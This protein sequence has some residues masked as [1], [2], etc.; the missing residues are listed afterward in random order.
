MFK[1]AIPDSVRLPV[2]TFRLGDRP[3]ALLIEDVVEV[4]AMVEAT[5]IPDAGPELIGMVNRRGMILPL[6]DLRVLFQQPASVVNSQSVFIVAQGGDRQIGLV[7]DEIRQVDYVDALQMSDA[8][9]TSRY[10]HGLI[11][12]KDEMIAVVALPPLLTAYLSGDVEQL[13]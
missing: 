11:S 10:I 7:V 12:H 1:Q 3:Y 4:T 13:E 6:L 9:A 2:L 5:P 8:P